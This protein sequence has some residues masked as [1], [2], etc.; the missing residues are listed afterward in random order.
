MPRLWNA[1]TLIPCGKVSDGDQQGDRWRTTR[2]QADSCRC[3]RCEI[4][5]MTLP[6]LFPSLSKRYASAAFSMGKT[7]P[8]TGRKCPCAVHAA[9]CFQASLINSRFAE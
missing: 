9:S 7:L 6:K 3:Y 1:Q 8:I 5:K 2:S 4:L